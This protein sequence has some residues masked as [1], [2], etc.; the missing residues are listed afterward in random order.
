[1]PTL[2]IERKVK[3]GKLF[4][5][6]ITSSDEA[7]SVQLTGDFFLE[8]EE[9]IDLIE[10]CLSDCLALSDERQAERVLSEKI[11]EV[12]IRISGIRGQGHHRRALGGQV[13]TWRLVRFEY[14]DAATNMALDEAVSEWHPAIDKPAD[15]KVLWLEAERRLHRPIPEPER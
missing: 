15:D 6:R 7:Q 8:P 11:A 9:G 5:L 3:G 2:V 13:M 1:M 14:H 4:R 10:R 12:H